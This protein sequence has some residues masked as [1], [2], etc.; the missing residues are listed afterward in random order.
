MAIVTRHPLFPVAFAPAVWRRPISTPT[1][2]AWSPTVDILDQEAAYVLRVDLPGMIQ[3]DIDIQFEHGVLTLKGQ[4]QDTSADSITY[5]RRERAHGTFVRRFNL[6]TDIETDQIS[7]TYRHG[8]L[9]IRLPKTTAAQMK[10]IPVKA[11]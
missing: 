1:H 8:V 4:R 9:E 11:A 6:G 7:A 2:T 3:D 5:Y 10:R